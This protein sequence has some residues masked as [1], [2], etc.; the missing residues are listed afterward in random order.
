MSSAENEVKQPATHAPGP[1]VVLEIC[2]EPLYIYAKRGMVADFH[3][4]TVPGHEP[5]VPDA[6]PVCRMR[7]VGAGMASDG[8]QMANARLIAASPTMYE[9]IQKQAKG[10]DEDAAQIIRSINDGIN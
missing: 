6:E 7:G 9:Y 1:W 8:T 10:G 2:S 3:H 4:L 5:E